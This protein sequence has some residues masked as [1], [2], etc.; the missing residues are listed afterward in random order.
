MIP[1]LDNA[2]L[3][4]SV[5]DML[6]RPWDVLLT[7][8]ALALLVGMLSLAL[9][10]TDSMAQTITR[11]MAESPSLVVRRL[12]AG[13]WAPIPE[14]ESIEAAKSIP[15]VIRAETRTW[16]VVRGP[17][18]VLTVI[19]SPGSLGA[20][21]VPDTL[22]RRPGPGE[23]IIGIGVT[24]D[25]STLS[26]R[27]A[28]KQERTLSVVGTF[29]TDSSL[30]THDLV[31]LHPDDAR[32]LLNIPERHAS[33]L[34][35]DVFHAEEATAILPDLIQAFPWPVQITTRHESMEAVQGGIFRRGSIATVALLPAILALGLVVLSAVRDRYARRYEIGLLKAL[36]WGTRDVFRMSLYR[37]LM[38]GMPSVALGCAAAYGL[39]YWTGAEWAG[40]WLLGWREVPVHLVLD[41]S[42]ASILLLE[43]AALVLVPFVAGV[44]FPALSSASADVQD[45]LEK[46]VL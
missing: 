37:A 14:R 18:G 7:G 41:V 44:V 46:G 1:P 42:G 6:R 43:V 12:N 8:A 11:L 26:L 36:G 17:S 10:L 2:F 3:L 5:R 34:I 13:G 38:I 20:G 15:G 30:F 29:S 28:T 25:G 21:R 33:D 40:R 24:T 9:I 4:W 23:A 16:G 32:E 39:V 22:P 31:L 45:F 35:I 27:G 19:A